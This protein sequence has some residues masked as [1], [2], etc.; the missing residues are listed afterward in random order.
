MGVR[1]KGRGREEERRG[2]TGRAE[3][4]GMRGGCGKDFRFGKEGF[5]GEGMFSCWWERLLGA[6]FCLWTEG[7]FVG[8]SGYLGVL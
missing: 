8:G 3:R 6:F 7:G 2:D 4:R 5:F 1:E